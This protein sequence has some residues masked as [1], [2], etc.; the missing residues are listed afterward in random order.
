MTFSG[1]FID[2]ALFGLLPAGVGVP[3][4]WIYIVI[5][6]VVLFGLYYLIFNFCVKKFDFKKPGREIEEG[7]EAHKGDK[8]DKSKESGVDFVAEVLIH[9]GIDTV[10][11]K[12][13][14]FTA[15]VVQGQEVKAGDFLVEVDIASIKGKVP[16]LC[17]PIIFPNLD[18][19][20]EIKI[21]EKKM[22]AAGAR[23]AATVKK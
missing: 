17:T 14:G 5:V 19:N 7:I 13:E 9:F 12:G 6:G 23:D 2:F 18:E 20:Q 8:F 4:N 16:S 10:Q 21:S 3:T 1:R 15:Y 11:L 22:L